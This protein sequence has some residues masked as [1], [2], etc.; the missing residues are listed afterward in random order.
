MAYTSENPLP[1]SSRIVAFDKNHKLINTPYRASIY[2]TPGDA[3]YRIQVEHF[4]GGRWLCVG[5]WSLSALVPRLYA[6]EPS[7]TLALDFGQ[8]WYVL[9]IVEALREALSLI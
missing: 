5:V 4:I 6:D 3:K 9:G 8:G 7:D 1:L 2:L